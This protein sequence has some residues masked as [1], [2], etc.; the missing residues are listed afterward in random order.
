[1]D[2]YTTRRSMKVAHSFLCSFLSNR[3]R[4]LKSLGGTTVMPTTLKTPCAN[5]NTVKCA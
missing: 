1:M 5:Y 2:F 4:M 3:W